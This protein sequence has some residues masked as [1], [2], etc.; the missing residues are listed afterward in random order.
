MRSTLTA[1]KRVIYS[2]PYCELC[3]SH[4]DLTVE[5]AESAGRTAP[6]APASATHQGV[7]DQHRPQVV[8][9]RCHERHELWLRHV[10][11]N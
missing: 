1:D 5:R 2:H 4:M 11:T 7:G 9:G 6:A 10:S 8:C 3:G